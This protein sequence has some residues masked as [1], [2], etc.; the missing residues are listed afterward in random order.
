MKLVP[1]ILIL[2]FATTAALSDENRPLNVT[3]DTSKSA[4]TDSAAEFTPRGPVGKRLPIIIPFAEIVMQDVF[5]W[6]WDRFVL[7]KDYAK[8]GPSYWKRNY[9]EGWKW[10]DNHFAINFF[11]HPY[12]GS[13]YFSAARA[14]GYNFYESYF[15]ALTGSYI[16]EMFCETEYPAPNDLIATSI[17]GS[18]YGEMLYRISTRALSKPDAGILENIFGFVASPFAYIQEWVNGP[19]PTNP[20]YAPMEWSV[21]AGVGR[22]F[23]NEF[24]YDQD[25][26]DRSDNDWNSPSGF[27]GLELIYGR[28]DRKLKLPFEYFTFSFNQDQSEDGMLMRLS[29]VGKLANLNFRASSSNWMDLGTYLHFDTFYGDLVEMTALSIGLGADVSVKLSDKFT[30]RMNH[31]PSYVILG[32]SDFNYDEV[33]AKADSSYEKTRD[34]QYSLGLSYKASVQLSFAERIFLYNYASAFLFHS[35]PNTEPHY[36]TKGY[37]F[38]FFNHLGVEVALPKDF[39][40][41]VDLNSYAKIAAYE[42]VE[43]MSRT[44]HSVGTYLR[45][46]I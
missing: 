20:G 24:R 7:Q 21:K 16:W 45:Y 31:M 30:F 5:V 38:V 37:D 33:L 4:A 36:G 1:G 12:Q 28:P 32:S 15:F 42:R 22:R 10:D 25:A 2:L 8:T 27:Y 35:W 41:G 14:S 11:G 9:R 18:I 6:G 3:K 17:G 43:P 26:D 19:S 29:S 23:G 13:M 34:Y 46:K 44:M 40:I 39:S